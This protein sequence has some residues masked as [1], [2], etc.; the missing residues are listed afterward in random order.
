[1][2]TEL[3]HAAKA[4]I[5]NHKRKNV[6]VISSTIARTTENNNHKVQSAILMPPYISVTP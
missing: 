6:G 1:M 4:P 2:K 3:I 5:E